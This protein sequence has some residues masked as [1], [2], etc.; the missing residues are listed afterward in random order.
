MLT[1]LN[2]TLGFGADAKKGDIIK[3]MVNDRVIKTSTL[4]TDA[5][6]RGKIEISGSEDVDISSLTK[7]EIVAILP[8]I[9]KIIM[10]PPVTPFAETRE[11]A[12]NILAKEADN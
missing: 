11:E 7:E 1:K 3:V 9:N 6:I 4:K 10:V 12:I 2:Q 8:E 5:E